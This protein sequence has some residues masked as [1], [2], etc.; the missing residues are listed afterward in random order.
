[1]NHSAYGYFFDLPQK[2]FE[3]RKLDLPI[4][5]SQEAVVKVLACGLCHT[6][7]SFFNGGVRTRKELPLVLGHEAVGKVI[8]AGEHAQYLLNKNVIVPAVLPCGDC[9]YCR[10]SRANACL[11]QKMPGN[12]INGG[13][14]SHMLVP[15]EPLVSLEDAPADFDIRY[16]SVAADAIS[17]AWQACK[18]ASLKKGDVVFVIGTGGVGGFVSQIA[19]ALGAHVVAGD[20]SAKRL[21]MIQN[22]G[23]RAVVNTSEGDI[24]SQ[25][26]LFSSEARAQKT[27]GLQIKIFECSGTTAGQAL[28][29][30]LLERGATYVQVGFTPKPVELRFSNIMAFDASIFGTWGCPPSEYPAVLQ[31]IYDGR[32]KIEP[33]AKIA[34]MSNIN[35][36]FDDMAGHKLK[37]RMILTPD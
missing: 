20:I 14:A 10:E 17:T 3:K 18:R 35:K 24:K 31:M 5:Q 13:F 32:V 25:R 4:P 29:F 8:Q 28:A 33:F 2:A 1:M 23:V 36:M 22:F 6:D 11:N 7:L 9:A 21:E 12:D 26:K 16:L 19:S 27:C 37:K 34:P 15:A 30:R